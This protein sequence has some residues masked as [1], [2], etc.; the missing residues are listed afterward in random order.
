MWRRRS[1]VGTWSLQ[2]T[3]DERSSIYFSVDPLPG[4]LESD[5]L[6]FRLGGNALVEG[7]DDTR[8]I[9]RVISRLPDFDHR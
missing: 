1:G 8:I 3:A 9:P 7:H 6:G 5:G 2:S 4:R